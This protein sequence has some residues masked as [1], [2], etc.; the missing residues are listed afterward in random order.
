MKGTREWIGLLSLVVVCLAPRAAYASAQALSPELMLQEGWYFEEGLRDLESAIGVYEKIVAQRRQN[1]TVAAKAQLRIAA[2]YERLGKEDLANRAYQRA[3]ELFADELKKIPEHRETLERIEA[4]FEEAWGKSEPVNAD[5]VVKEIL[6]DVGIDT[7]RAIC[8]SYYRLAAEHVKTELPKAIL[9]YRK[10]IAISTFLGQKE[11][12]AHYQC[13]IG[14]IYHSLNRFREA[15]G[16]YRKAQRDFPDVKNI[17]AWTQ[18]RI[19]ETCRLVGDLGKAAD[20]YREMHTK[21]PDQTDQC[22]WADVWRADIFREKNN[23]EL[24]QDIWHNVAARG[25]SDQYRVQAQIASLMLEGT[26]LPEA[27]ASAKPDDVFA[28]DLLYFVGV[29]REMTGDV[30][31]A[32]ESYRACVQISVNNDWPCDLAAQAL[33]RLGKAAPKPSDSAVEP[34]EAKP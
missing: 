8:D 18:M 31:A 21:Y 14:D 3:R 23:L 15:L 27:E 34:S 19:A 33:S 4:K 7:A 29:R 22:V 2:C 1:A 12:S 6:K 24:A 26:P 20:A 28:N 30:E 17:A 9:S 25:Q 5:R 32:A 13:V 16:A 10:A 11:R